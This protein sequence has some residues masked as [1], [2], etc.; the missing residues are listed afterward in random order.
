MHTLC[1]HHDMDIHSLPERTTWNRPIWRWPFGSERTFTSWPIC[2]VHVR[3]FVTL[4][5]LGSH[6]ENAIKKPL[7]IQLICAKKKKGKKFCN[8][9][10]PLLIEFYKYIMLVFERMGGGLYKWRQMKTSWTYSMSII[11]AFSFAAFLID[12]CKKMNHIF[13]ISIQ[14]HA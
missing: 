6:S 4:A 8:S 2:A 14:S 12:K 11:E 5:R 3:C 1:M 7:L 10:F 13:E 9:S